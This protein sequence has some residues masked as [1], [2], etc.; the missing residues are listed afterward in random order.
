LQTF[1]KEVTLQAGEVGGRNE[2]SRGDNLLGRGHTLK[3]LQ[4]TKEA[5]IRKA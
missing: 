2:A 1:S 4:V 3:I 5:T